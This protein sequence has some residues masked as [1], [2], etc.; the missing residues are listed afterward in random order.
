MYTYSIPKQGLEDLPSLN[1]FF[2]L[3]SIEGAVLN[4]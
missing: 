3:K 4:Q 2:K 1:E